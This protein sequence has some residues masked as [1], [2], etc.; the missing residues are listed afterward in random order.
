M[1]L[2]L[3]N[4]TYTGDVIGTDFILGNLLLLKDNPSRYAVIQ[5]KYN[6]CNRSI[7][8]AFARIYYWFLVLEGITDES[9][10]P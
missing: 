2:K 9:C 3:N 6:I 5:I 1:L 8:G 7:F 4:F 10:Q